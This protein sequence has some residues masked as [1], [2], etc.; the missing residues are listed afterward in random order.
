MAHV[1]VILE[2]V[3][4]A[5]VATHTSSPVVPLHH[6]SLLQDGTF[7]KDYFLVLEYVRR[8]HSIKDALISFKPRARTYF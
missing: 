8:C 2:K 3:G 1:R 4:E 7:P 5:W 6:H